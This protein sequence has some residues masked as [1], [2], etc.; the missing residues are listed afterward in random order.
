MVYLEPEASE[1]VTRKEKEKP[2]PHAKPV[3]KRQ[4]HSVFNADESPVKK[5]KID[6]EENDELSSF[7][8]Y[9]TCLLKK[10][11]PDVF[12]NVQIEIINTILKAN[13]QSSIRS[14]VLNKEQLNTCSKIITVDGITPVTSSMLGHNYTITV[15]QPKEDDDGNS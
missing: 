10:L 3:R 13:S 4:R 8:K 1:T 11:P 12:S 5:T 2:R 15:A 6:E 9:I 7:I 14:I